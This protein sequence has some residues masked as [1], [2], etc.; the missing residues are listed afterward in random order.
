MPSP[1]PG[2]NPCL[3]RASVWH[4]FHEVLI[5]EIR[6]AL[7][8]QIRPAL[9]ATLVDNVYLHKLPAVDVLRENFIEIRDRESRELVTVIE[10]LSPTNK[11]PGSD[12]DQFLNKRYQLLSSTAHYV[13]IDLL[14]GE[15][16]LPIENLPDCDAYAMV[17]RVEERP[18][19]GLWPV[20][21][22]EPLPTIPIPLRAP[23]A[24]AR[25]DLQAI[26]HQAYDAGGYED[27]L[28]SGAPDVPL[29]DDDA[30]WARELI[31]RRP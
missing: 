10:L 21:L 26:L 2:M 12:R 23:A 8:P 16:R 9:I 7:V 31:S 29:S 30:A 19:V 18:H 3:E 27:Y 4:D 1:F 28:Y 11:R 14:R 17:S 15:P 24:D 5:V 13:E 6:R 20:S 22:L 25:I